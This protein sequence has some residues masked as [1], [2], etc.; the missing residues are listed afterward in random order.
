[1]EKDHKPLTRQSPDWWLLSVARSTGEPLD[2]I[3]APRFDGLAG[4]R[5]VTAVEDG[6]DRPKERLEFSRR[7]RPGTH[8]EASSNGSSEERAATIQPRPPAGPPPAR[9]GRLSL[10]GCQAAVGG[11]PPG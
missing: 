4:A 11:R 8:G 3:P 1:M 7:R 5:L 9:L 2:D 10:R 6:L